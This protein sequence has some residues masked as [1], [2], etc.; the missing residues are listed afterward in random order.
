[1]RAGGGANGE[2]DSG[3]GSGPCLGAWAEQQTHADDYVWRMPPLH[4]WIQCGRTSSFRR[5]P[6][7]PQPRGASE[8]D[9]TNPQSAGA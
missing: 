3:W 5:E 6:D 2:T 7:E 9:C 1:M 8:S 4:P